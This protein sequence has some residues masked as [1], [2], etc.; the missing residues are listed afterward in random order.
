[1]TRT[2][3]DL[4]AR[5]DEPALRSGPEPDASAET[6]VSPTDRRPLWIALG[7]LVLPLVVSAGVLL[8]RVGSSFHA[9]GDNAQNELH[10]RDVG[11]HLVTLGPYSRDGWNHLGPAMYY[12]LA[13][14]YRLTGSYS[15]GMYVGALLINA[16]AVAGMTIIAWRRGGLAVALLTVLGLAVVMQNLGPEFLREPWNPYITVLPFG[17]LMFMVW[18]L[19]AGRAW[20]LPAAAAVAT[21]LVQTHV[22]YVPLAIPLFF[23]GA[24]WLV[25]VAR[26]R[27]HDGVDGALEWPRVTRAALLAALVLVVMWTPPV[28]GMIRHTP[29]NLGTA[30]RYFINGKGNHNLLD[31]YRVV[32]QQFST[33]PEWVIGAHTPN[34]FSG[35]PD[36][37]VHTPVP[38]LIIPFALAVWLLWRRRVGEGARLAAIVAVAS[39]LGILAVSRTIGP[40]YFYRLRWTWLLGMLGV[41]LVGWALWVVASA[42]SRPSHK[43]RLLVPVAVAIVALTAVN[44]ASAA[45]TS[46]P[47]KP[48]ST[49]LANL[50]PTLRRAIPNR[51][52]VVLVR[53]GGFSFSG[54]RNGLVLWLERNGIEARVLDALEAAQ[55][56][57][58]QRVYHGEAIRTIVTLGADAAYDTLAADPRERRVAYQGTLPPAERAA[59]VSRLATLRQQSHPGPPSPKEAFFQALLLQQQAGH[60]V[61]VFLSEP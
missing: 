27:A 54:Y 48:D 58:V 29:G 22:G 28:I 30:T 37:L 52:G 32:A 19:S 14:P 16:V 23:G 38:W 53:Q 33:R 17:L 40:V 20:A 8:I 13:L 46:T 2:R 49:T 42:A 59:V 3:R 43:A 36:F 51:T 39:A 1:V 25:L 31:G 11:H 56:V 12:L 45:R 60:A 47:T 44:T 50:L 24:A 9:L 6:W 35:E 21:F 7:L 4:T 10:T 41:V 15:V 55:G 18:E 57:G 34:S 26:R 61:G 5:G